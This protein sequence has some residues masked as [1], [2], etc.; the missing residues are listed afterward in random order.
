MKKQVLLIPVLLSILALSGF[1]MLLTSQVNGASSDA[2]VLSYSWYTVTT[3]DDA[4]TVREIRVIGEIENVG[5]TNI[6]YAYVVATAFIDDVKIASVSQEAYGINI[7]P[8][9]KS[10]FYIAI[11][12]QNLIDDEEITELTGV[13]DIEVNMGYVATNNNNVSVDATVSSK[14]DSGNSHTVT[15]T[16]AFVYETAAGK[17]AVISSI[18]VTATYY[19]SKG[20]VVSLGRTGLLTQFDNEGPQ[21]VPFTITPIDTHFEKDITSYELFI[22]YNT[23]QNTNPPTQTQPTPTTST[24][25]T[26]TPEGTPGGTQ[27]KL[28]KTWIIATVLIIAI[29][30]IAISLLLLTRKKHNTHNNPTNN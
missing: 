26:A 28:D 7:Q 5:K 4:K 17:D 22:Q 23:R 20:T 29:I 15:G 30:A 19:N 27:P 16:I 13:T 8:G 12:A 18:R 11:T 24:S 2:K 10:P 9:Q 14:K 1:T 25:P 6:A 3:N 21:G